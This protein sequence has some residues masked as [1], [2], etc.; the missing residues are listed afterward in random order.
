MHVRLHKKARATPA[1]VRERQASTDPPEVL[2]KRYNLIALTVD[3][4]R[5]RET[6]EDPPTGAIACRPTFPLARSCWWGDCAS[7]CCCPRRSA[8][9]EP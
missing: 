3:K 9:G 2:S 4:W 7:S 8:H 5:R 1:I 6:S